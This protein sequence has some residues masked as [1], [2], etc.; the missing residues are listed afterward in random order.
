MASD[1]SPTDVRNRTLGPRIAGL[2][3]AAIAAVL[4]SGKAI[5][6]KLLYRHD[7]D[8]ATVIALR[9]AFAAPIFIAIA[10]WQTRRSEPL[11]TR[12]RYTIGL[13]GFLGYYLS[14]L[15]DFWGL[16]YV[17]ATLE[18]LILFLTPTMVLLISAVWFRR[19]ITSRQWLAMAVCYAG[20]VLV[21]ADNLRFGGRV[22]FGSALIFGATVSYSLYLIVSG[23][24]VKR[25]GS[26]RLVA[27]V[28]C[29]ACALSIAHFLVVHSPDA[30]FRQAPEVLQLSAI[31]A[32][33]CTVFPVFLTMYAIARIGA[34]SASQ[35]SL[36][37]P[38]SLVFLGHWILGEPITLLQLIGTAIV[39]GGVMIVSS[40]PART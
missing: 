38:V 36:L 8:P 19:R 12:D 9:M 34:P 37:G 28:M 2:S 6:I 13:L 23:E 15:L 35:L 29:V 27:Y 4:F 24:I 32:L 18:R 5:V 40:Q 10:W 25:I 21:F 1:I 39:I 33:F 22:V 11:A 30:L 17:S 31:N 14:S 20:I 26:T 7:V 16:Q 3:M